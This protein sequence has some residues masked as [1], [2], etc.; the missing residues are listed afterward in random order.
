MIEAIIDYGSQAGGAVATLPSSPATLLASPAKTLAGQPVNLFAEL[1]RIEI[2]PCEGKSQPSAR[3][4][5][6]LT[7]ADFRDTYQRYHT[8]G[9]SVAAYTAEFLHF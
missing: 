4:L 6:P 1:P 5:T 8:I 2:F 7:A 3:S 9:I